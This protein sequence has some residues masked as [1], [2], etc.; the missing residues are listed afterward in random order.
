MLCHLS[1]ASA[2]VEWDSKQGWLAGIVSG[3]G[4]GTLGMT[5]VRVR[6]PGN[7]IGSE[8]RGYSFRNLEIQE[9]SSKTE[10]E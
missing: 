8:K 1:L 9:G 7:S 6:C 10:G 3:S 5:V 2:I 4:R